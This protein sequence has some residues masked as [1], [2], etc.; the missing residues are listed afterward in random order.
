MGHAYIC[1]I[2]LFQVHK[3]DP[4][5][6]SVNSESRGRS[7][8]VPSAVRAL[9]RPR[10]SEFY[11]GPEPCLPHL[12]QS[13]SAWKLYFHGGFSNDSQSSH[14]QFGK[15][16]K[17]LAAPGPCRNLQ[18]HQRRVPNIILDDL[19]SA[20]YDDY[21][22]EPELADSVFFLSTDHSPAKVS[23][24]LECSRGHIIKHSFLCWC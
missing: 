4:W 13:M 11:V 24:G 16:T 7:C 1:V 9:H 3:L 17:W 21:C 2:R 20:A 8:G 15:G 5:G 6:R 19:F 18:R 10:V 22:N 12:V 23:P 14:K